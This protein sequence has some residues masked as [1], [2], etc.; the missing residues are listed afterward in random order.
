MKQLSGVL[1]GIVL[2]TLAWASSADAQKGSSGLE[3][4]LDGLREKVGA[5]GDS[6]EDFS[7]DPEKMMRRQREASQDVLQ[8]LDGLLQLAQQAES[9][10]AETT[11][12]KTVT[13]Y[14]Y[15]DDK[16][17]RRE[18]D[19]IEE[20]PTAEKGRAVKVTE[21]LEVEEDSEAKTRP[22]SKAPQ[23]IYRYRGEQGRTLYTNVEAQI[24]EAERNEAIMDLSHI[25]LNSA[26]GTQINR[27]MEQ[28]HKKLAETKFCKSARA[29]PEPVVPPPAAGLLGKAQ[30]LW[31]GYAPLIVCG[32]LLLLLFL[33]SPIMIRKVDP[34]AW[35][36]VLMFALPALVVGG[37]SAQMLM[38]TGQAV[39]GFAS[40]SENCDPQAFEGLL[41]GQ[42]PLAAR[43]SML[44]ALQKQMA[45]G[46]TG[47]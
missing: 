39:S 46:A 12:L 40:V 44:Q 7:A 1:H 8:Q 47:Q 31:A 23:T 21:P 15:V 35:R 33:I 27:K 36:R 32:G 37:G 17:A 22:A 6:T 3:G 18:V 45:G 4:L 9:G 28:A 38:K 14:I 16:G 11:P 41:E 13:R 24:P 5:M 10:A 2:L 29:R 20:V 42:S 19:S 26:M 30:T 34:Y 43:L 25:P